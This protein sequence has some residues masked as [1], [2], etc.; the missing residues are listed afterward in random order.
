MSK[1]TAIAHYGTLVDCSRNGVINLKSAKRWM[2]LTSDL[3]C[4]FMMLY[5]EDVFTLPEEPYFGYMRGRYTP[6]EL[7]E[8]DD[9]ACSRGMEL[10]PCFQGLAHMNAIA[11]WPEYKSMIDTGDIML[12]GDERTYALLDKTFAMYASCVRTKTYRICL[13][14]A[15]LMGRGKYYELHGDRKQSDLLMEHLGKLSEIAR[16][17]GVDFVVDSDMF[18]NLAT[19]GTYYDANAKFDDSIKSLIPDNVSLE[20]WDFYYRDKKDYDRMIKSHKKLTDRVWYSCGLWNWNGFTPQST[21]AISAIRRAFQSCKDYGVD[22]VVIN[23]WHDDGCECSNFATLPALFFA[24]KT[25]QG[26][27]SMTQIKKEFQEKFG[28]SFDAF[29]LLDAPGSAGVEH[30]DKVVG[31][32]EKKYLYNDCFMGLLDFSMVGGENEYFAACARKLGRYKAVPEFGAL[33]EQMQALCQVLAIKAELGKK[34]HEVYAS[35]DK[36]ALKALIADYKT[37]QKRLAKF[38]KLFEAR[39]LTEF[40][41]QGLEIQSMRL[42]GLQARIEFCEGRLQALYDGKID[43]IEEL[44]EKQLPYDCGRTLLPKGMIY[45]WDKIV[46]VG[47]IL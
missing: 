15:Y 14:E 30:P 35:G 24:C 23:S 47:V 34:T 9:Y 42:G 38:R 8:L 11:R 43:R 1:N 10:I 31:C 46:S 18:Y 16:K 6:E 4:S 33:F 27:T 17:Y 39:W 45:Q 22:H 12:I 13:D 5:T 37:V 32:M 40:K 25:A 44:E 19:G 7:K 29:R 41:P 36:D 2:D 3:G 21:Y 26:V 20:Y 28:I